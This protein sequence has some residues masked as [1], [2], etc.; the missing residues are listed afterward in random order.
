MN[1]Y[2]KRELIVK[3]RRAIRKQ[4]RETTPVPSNAKEIASLMVEYANL[5][6]SLDEAERAGE[7]NG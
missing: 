5:G 7:A 3:A 2:T 6:A 1:Q 4:I